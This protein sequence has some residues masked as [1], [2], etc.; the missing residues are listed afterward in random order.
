MEEKKF[1]VGFFVFVLI[2][3]VVG[4]GGFFILVEQGASQETL[5][6]V[7]G[8]LIFLFAFVGIIAISLVVKSLQGEKKPLNKILRRC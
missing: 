2:L 4:F 8:G 7:W 3:L 1:I 5:T 6:V